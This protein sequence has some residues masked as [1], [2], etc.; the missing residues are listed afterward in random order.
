MI[1]ASRRTKLT[2]PQ[3]AAQWGVD[4]HKIVGWIRS[5]ELRAI[6][7]ATDR[8]GRPR[9]AIDQADIAV[10]EASRAVQPPMPRLRR[11]RTDPGVTQFF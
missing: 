2:P 1:A 11:R 8:N 10:F 3:L 7:L 9:Y 5:G 6:N 4:V